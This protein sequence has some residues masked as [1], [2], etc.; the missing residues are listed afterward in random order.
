ML[1]ALSLQSCNAS[2]NLGLLLRYRFSSGPRRECLGLRS[3]Y[4]V[5]LGRAY[6]SCGLG[7]N[8]HRGRFPAI[9]PRSPWLME[10]S[11]SRREHRLCDRCDHC[12]S[13]ESCH[14]E[15][16]ASASNG[17][18]EPGCER[19]DVVEPGRR[20]RSCQL[21]APIPPPPFI[22]LVSFDCELFVRSL[23]GLVLSKEEATS[24]HICDAQ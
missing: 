17:Q 11:V 10:K 3:G 4:D 13:S 19:V 9:A 7:G 15:L 1:S 6:R 23:R 24:G 18:T 20:A 5:P 22:G 8:R 21:V 12:H 14:V 2:R 16:S